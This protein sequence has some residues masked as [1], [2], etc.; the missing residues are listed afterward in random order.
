MGAMISFSE[1]NCNQ[2]LL[3]S[4]TEGTDRLLI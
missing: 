4:L 2:R 3:T 1:H